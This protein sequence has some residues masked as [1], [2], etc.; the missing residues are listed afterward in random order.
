MDA[1]L[2]TV[3]DEMVR[4]GKRRYQEAIDAGLSCAEALL[5]ADNG[6]DVGQLRKLVQAGCPSVLIASIVT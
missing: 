2:D 3:D 5:F 1:D 6:V 4:V